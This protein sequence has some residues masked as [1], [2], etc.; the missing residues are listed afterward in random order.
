METAY[1][2]A[3]P[4]AVALIAPAVEARLA[5]RERIHAISKRIGATGTMAYDGDQV[6]YWILSCGAAIPEGWKRAPRVRGVHGVVPDRKHAAGRAVW[7]EIGARPALPCRDLGARPTTILTDGA[8]IRE[9]YG[10]ERHGSAWVVTARLHEGRVVGGDPRG[11]RR[12]QNSEYWLLREAADGAPSEL[13]LLRQLEHAVRR[14][15]PHLTPG[16]G[17]GTPLGAALL[18][19]EP[20]AALD[21]AQA[22]LS[23]LD[24]VRA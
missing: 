2:V 15:L 3:G 19:D 13:G 22:T 11:C 5:Y 9:G 6:A 10:Y 24:K 23:A 1:F 12:I 17:Y 7:A 18:M 16:A 20:K 4:E 14:M 21:D 8:I